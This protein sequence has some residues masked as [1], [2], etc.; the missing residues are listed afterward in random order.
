VT[1]RHLV[2]AAVYVVLGLFVLM[3]QPAVGSILVV[4]G[5]G[6]GVYTLRPLFAERTG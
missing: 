4:S 6:L 2:Y 1:W 3:L 5:L